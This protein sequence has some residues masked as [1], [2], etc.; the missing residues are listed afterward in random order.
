MVETG[1]APV[2]RPCLPHATFVGHAGSEAMRPPEGAGRRSITGTRRP[3]AVSRPGRRAIQHAMFDDEDPGGF[4]DVLGCD[5]TRSPAMSE[6][7]GGALARCALD[8]VSRHASLAVHCR[9]GMSW[10]ATVAGAVAGKNVGIAFPRAHDGHTRHVH[11]R[12][13]RTTM[14]AAES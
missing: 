2:G 9:D 12:V 11:G 13:G 3:P 10:S 1:A 8:A 4:S 14:S 7:R 6:G 5:R